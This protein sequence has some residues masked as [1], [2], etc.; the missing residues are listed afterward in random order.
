M[1]KTFKV[2]CILIASLFIIG[3]HSEQG[4][5]VIGNP[6][7]IKRLD[8]HEAVWYASANGTGDCS[9][10]AEACSLV[11]ALGNITD[12]VHD[13][14]YLGGGL[15]DVASAGAGGVTVTGDYWELEGINHNTHSSQIINSDAS[16]THMITVS[17]SQNFALEH[18]FFSNAEQIDKDVISLTMTGTKYGVV[19]DCFF[20]AHSTAT[21]GTAIQLDGGAAHTHIDGSEITRLPDYGLH[22]NNASGVIVS[23]NRFGHNIG[24][25]IF[26]EHAST[27]NTL[28]RGIELL[29]NAVAMNFDNGT[30]H[31]VIGATFIGNTTNTIEAVAVYG[32]IEWEDING[33]G[34][35]SIYPTTAAGT[36]ITTGDGSWVWTASATTVIPADTFT[37]SFRIVDLYV[38]SYDASQTYQFEL[39]YGESTATTSMNS[40]EFTVGSTFFGLQQDV[41]AVVGTI[42]PA[43]SIIG[44]KS[45]SNTAGTDDFEVVLRVEAL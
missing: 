38:R 7:T 8:L 16:A 44:I 10:R 28:F 4:E 42:V 26:I 34:S 3:G 18:L 15:H 32:E 13:T 22:I 24:D 30:D 37:T 36:T 17:G 23:D 33:F 12:D 43:R 1:K 39:F 45:R 9:T 35:K 5:T 14:I 21:T 27:T 2:F 11:T 20:T 31:H 40:G 41:K 25:A 6:D 19:Y 29:D